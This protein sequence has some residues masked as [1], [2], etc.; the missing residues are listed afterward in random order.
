MHGGGS[1]RS[2]TVVARLGSCS[3][4]GH[5]RPCVPQSMSQ[6]MTPLT[7]CFLWMISALNRV[8]MPDQALWAGSYP[9]FWQIYHMTNSSALAVRSKILVLFPSRQPL[10]SMAQTRALLSR[11]S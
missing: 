3:N 4:F 7:I 2:R 11:T 6:M 9:R 10:V 5:G 8:W 1:V